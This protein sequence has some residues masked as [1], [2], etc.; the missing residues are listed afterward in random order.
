MYAKISKKIDTKTQKL[1]YNSEPNAEGAI[2]DLKNFKYIFCLECQY[3]KLG[4]IININQNVIYIDCKYNFIT[5][6][7]NLPEKLNTLNCSNNQ[8]TYLDNLPEKLKKL[9][10]S[11]NKITELNNLP[12]NL[13]YLDCDKND[14]QKLDN[15]PWNIKEL[16]VGLNMI[17]SL[18]YLPETLKILNLRNDPF[19]N[20]LKENK[21][22]LEN[23]PVSLEIIHTDE[24][25]QLIIIGNKTNW[26]INKDCIV[27]KKYIETHEQPKTFSPTLSNYLDNIGDDEDEYDYN[28]NN[29][30]EHY[31]YA[32]KFIY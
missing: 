11:N 13:E 26:K 3:S 28:Y 4:L 12:Q 29:I 18:D 10:C 5:R 16:V 25:K 32:F 8:I 30:N 20:S 27:R 17:S 15:L 23:L 19:D 9:I 24:Y 1:L 31:C 14:I 22:N 21:L 6:F 7:D 2:L